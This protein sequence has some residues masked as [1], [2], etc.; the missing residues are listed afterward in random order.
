MSGPCTCYVV[1]SPPVPVPR[2]PSFLLLGIIII[3]IVPQ[4]LIRITVAHG[5]Y[6]RQTHVCRAYRPAGFI[7]CL[8]ISPYKSPR[9]TYRVFACVPNLILRMFYPPFKAKTNIFIRFIREN[10]SFSY[11]RV[12]Y[13]PK[14]DTG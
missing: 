13:V 7:D 14:K 3:I 11:S 9:C 6:G 4:S 12:N 8:S 10:V 5:P 1:R 2:S